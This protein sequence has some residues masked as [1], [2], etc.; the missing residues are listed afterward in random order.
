[1]GAV[2]RHIDLFSGIGGFALACKWVGIE[3]EVFCERDKFCQ[4]ML[5]KHWPGVPIIEDIRDFDGTAYTGAFIL[6]GGFPCQPFSCAGKQRGNQ[7]D[8]YLWREMFKVIKE[9]RPRWVL[10]ENVA[11]IVKME[12]ENVLSDLE[13]EGYATGTLIIPA[14]AKDA[15]HR[16]DRIWIVGNASEFRCNGLSVG[17]HEREK[18]KGWMRELTG[19]N[20]HA[21]HSPQRQDD[22]RNTR[23]MGEETE[24]REGC[25]PAVGTGNQYA[26]DAKGKR[27][28][29]RG[30]WGQGIAEEGVR[31]FPTRPNWDE[32]WIEAATRLCAMDDGLPGG[33][34]RPKGWRVN[35]LKAA[36]N[37]IVPQIAF[38]IIKAI[39]QVENESEM[40]RQ[41]LRVS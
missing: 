16:R 10:A 8:R 33:L 15:P 38:E 2:C 6:T 28:E 18:E 12:L 19:T 13:G 9:A 11:G 14:C 3:T 4:R 30:N 24:G 20:S 36:G 21:P 32:P 25:N 26:E 41:R 34:V 29:R 23:V 27:L 39:L 7:D 37:A 1:M 40:L 35:A 5:R 31:L 17:E 22:N